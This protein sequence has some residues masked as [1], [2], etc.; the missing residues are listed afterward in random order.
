MIKKFLRTKLPNLWKI[1]KINTSNE[2]LENINKNDKKVFIFLAADYPNLGDIA[3]TYAQ[4]IFLKECYPDYKVIEIPADKTISLLKNVKKIINKN[5]VITTVG[6]GNMGNIYEYYEDLRRTVIKTF[7]DNY[8]I[9]FPQTIDFSNDA[10]GKKLLRKTEKIVKR[11]R[12]ILIYARE[13]KSYKKMKE[14][15]GKEKVKIAPDIVLSLKGKMTINRNI[16][17]KTGICFRNDKE[18][19]L[20]KI[21]IKEEILNL[22]KN[23]DKLIFDTVLDKEKFS[24]EDRYKLLLQTLE[25]IANCKKLYTNRL[26][27][28][29]FAYL[30]ET[31]CYFIDNTNKK[32]SETYKRWLSNTKFIKEYNKE[33][34]EYNKELNLVKIFDNM[35][36]EIIE[37]DKNG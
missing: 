1:Y 16:T 22:T 30:M 33:E 13:E 15:F 19:D 11:H 23:D 26:H 27:A 5:D 24:Y 29:I 25:K 31:R 4:K 20:T 35:K 14:I 18:E 34:K 32:I 8:I 21:K 7:K 12:N 17:N 2:K 36:K 9:S 10:K 28:M 6:G 37:G 3:I